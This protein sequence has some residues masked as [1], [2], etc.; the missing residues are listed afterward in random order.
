MTNVS[1]CCKSSISISIS[2]SIS[3][4]ISISISISMSMSISIHSQK[5]DQCAPL[6]R[7]AL[8]CC[9]VQN[10]FSYNRMCSLTIECVLLL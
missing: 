7:V 4:S 6:L 3:M 2:I 10:V 8:S 1:P 5:C 9:M